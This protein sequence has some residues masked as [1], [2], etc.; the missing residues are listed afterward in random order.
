[1][2]GDDA[3]IGGDHM[4]LRLPGIRSDAGTARRFLADRLPSLGWEERL[5]DACL[6]LSELIANVVLHAHTGCTVVLSATDDVLRV[7]VEDGS[8]VMPR[9]QT[10]STDATTGRGMHL[11]DRM[12]DSW[13]AR[14]FAQ[15]KVVWFCLGR[16]QLDHHVD[17]SHV[18]KQARTILDEAPVGL[19]ASLNQYPDWTNGESDQPVMLTSTRPCN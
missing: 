12:A 18:S 13:G 17:P 1:V 11:L 4:V 10:F 9:K 14:P 3:T 2:E 7:E 8:P 15:G 6:L 19:D 5:N 16:A